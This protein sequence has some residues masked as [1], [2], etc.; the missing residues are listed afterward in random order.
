MSKLAQLPNPRQLK[1]QAAVWILCLEEGLSEQDRQRLQAWLEEDPGHRQALVRMAELWDAYGALAELADV[2]PLREHERH[3]TRSYVLKA[4][5]IAVAGVGLATGAAY[6][7]A[8]RN[9]LSTAPNPRAQNDEPHRVEAAVPDANSPQGG[10]GAPQTVALSYQ[11]GV[12]KK[13]SERLPDGSEITLNTNTLLNVYYTR[14]ER[15]V[16][17]AR[18]EAV[19]TVAH[20]TA[21]PFRVLAGSRVVQAVGTVF[22]VKLSARED[23]RVTVSEGKIKILNQPAS[24]RALGASGAA[25][26]ELAVS[27]GELAVIGSAGEQVQPIAPEQIEASLAWRHGML[28]YRGE[29]LDAVLADF[30]RYTTVR[31]S[32][33]DDSIR[34]KRVGGYFRV[35]DV[36]GVLLALRESFGIE[37]RREGDVIVLTARR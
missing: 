6:F 17:L 13:Q 12:G 5:A 1:E 14:D 10:P 2:L 26:R 29:T 21:R 4:A 34:G 31:F 28:V 22:N 15:R 24:G 18:G 9:L 19:F 37:T 3:R 30:S 7:L 11:T 25:P 8:G 16:V 32:I 27:A 35:G 36:D 20:D 23:V 33:A